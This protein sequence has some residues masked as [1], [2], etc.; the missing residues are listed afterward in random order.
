[1]SQE[2][3]RDV[4]LLCPRREPCQQLR[5][6]PQCTAC[7]IALRCGAGPSDDL[8][9]FGEFGTVNCIRVSNAW[10]AAGGADEPCLLAEQILRTRDERLRMNL[11]ALDSSMRAPVLYE[12]VCPRCSQARMIDALFYKLQVTLGDTKVTTA[13]S[14]TCD[15][16][17]L[18]A[19]FA[20]T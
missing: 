5:E 10:Y 13:F 18:D 7:E 1:M 8:T 12:Q 14:L 19:R 20:L 16:C 2:Y 15:F 17:G 9:V 6:V 4:C 11:E 3:K